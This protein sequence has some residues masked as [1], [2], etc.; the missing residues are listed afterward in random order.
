MTFFQFSAIIII[1]KQRKEEFSWEEIVD[2]VSKY[3]WS[4]AEFKTICDELEFGSKTVSDY[5]GLYKILMKEKK[6]NV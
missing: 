2:A 5:P 6:K 1:E 4:I 3:S